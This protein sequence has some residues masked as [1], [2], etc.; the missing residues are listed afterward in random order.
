MGRC[1]KHNWNPRCRKTRGLEWM[2]QLTQTPDKA[3]FHT[4]TWQV[5][6]YA[7]KQ[8]L[9][10]IFL[11]MINFKQFALTKDKQMKI[12]QIVHRLQKQGFFQD[13]GVA[14]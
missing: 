6:T 3:G 9:N 8:R 14:Q 2:T 12:Y 13:T 5:M 1:N 7:R 11:R 4:P 10:L